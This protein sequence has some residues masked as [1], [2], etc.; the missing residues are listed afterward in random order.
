M[1]GE[2]TVTDAWLWQLAPRLPLALARQRCSGALT[3]KCLCNGSCPWKS[4]SPTARERRALNSNPSSSPTRKTTGTTSETVERP[5]ANRH[6]EGFPQ[7]LSQL[8]WS[9]KHKWQ[10]QRLPHG[11]QLFWFAVLT[12]F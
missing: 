10:Q 8:T 5:W 3:S 1:L 7:G 11:L 2:E 9:D 12:R 6:P 4:D